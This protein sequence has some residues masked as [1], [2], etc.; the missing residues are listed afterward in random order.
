MSRSHRLVLTGVVPGLLAS[1]AYVRHP[2]ALQ[3]GL[4]A[5][6]PLQG[7]LT[8]PHSGRQNLGPGTVVSHEKIS[9]TEGGFSGTLDDD[10]FGSSVA[11][12]GD[13][14]GD[15][16]GDLAV[17]APYD[18]DGGIDRGAVWVLFLD[19][20]GTV[21]SHQ[22][23][24]DTEG[25]F[26][27]TLDDEDW[28]GYSVAALGD[29]D[30]DGIG[31]LAVGAPYDD[32]GGIDR[33][34]L[35]VLFL[36]ADGT[37]ESHQKISHT[38]GGFTG[39]LDQGDAFGSSV[40]ALGDLDGDG[41]G[42]LAVGAPSDDDGGGG[43][44][45]ER[46]A[47]WVLFLDTDGTVQ[48]QQ[49]IS[50][51]EGGFTGTLDDSDNLGSSAAGLGDLDGDGTEDLAAGAPRDDDGGD[52]PFSERGAVWVLFLDADGTVKGHQKISDTE[53]GFTGTLD[54]HDLLG[55]S[56]AGLGDLDADGVP[57][58]ASGAPGDDDGGPAHGA[59]WLLRLDGI[60]TVGFESGDDQGR[61]ALVNGQDISSPPE[62]GRTLGLAGSGA[63]LGP[64]IFDS[65][66]FGPNDPSQD[67]DLL[68]DLG[69][70]LI[71]QNSLVP[72]QTVPGI[73]D[74][75]N[76]DQDGGT[77]TFTFVHGAVEPSSLD[78][79]DIDL[80][81]SQMASV[82]LFD[83]SNRLRLYDIP[84]GWTEDLVLH[85]FPGFRTLDL[86]TLD[87]QPGFM[88]SASAVETPG[89]D[90]KAVVRIEVALG[91]SG[92]VDNLRWDPHPD[93]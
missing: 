83:S 90:P 9:D 26:T 7:G 64:A 67:L 68:V 69:N 93:L 21:A 59:L 45:S 30:A 60:A 78:L 56:V 74:R 89:F 29:L 84:A 2:A 28:F 27:G 80:G 50:D 19:A 15:R 14:D 31:D 52:D 91:S 85:G 24:S 46:G 57:D 48:G 55:S 22:K 23:I 76:D 82:T 18:D 35:W 32:D 4:P 33:G 42:D 86:T 58:L 11:S 61:T 12:I 6:P 66:P 54:P 65:T 41:I 72:A 40:A 20:G 36:D 17:G 81:D 43:P 38:E 8:Y 63:N 79:V 25:G 87:P 88:A 47:V 34:A 71:L 49:K 53:G 70:L 1:L 16:I 77:F 37:V 13:L 62:F 44:L 39:S 10:G 92:A 5:S 51:T 3:Q 75:P 73:F